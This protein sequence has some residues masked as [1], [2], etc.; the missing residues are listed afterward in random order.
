MRLAPE[1]HHGFTL[2]EL[3]VVIAILAILAA[4]L[5][6]VFAQAREKARAT[7]C[8][9][10]LRQLTM[11]IHQYMQDWEGGL[12]EFQQE[13]TTPEEYL[14]FRW[15]GHLAPYLKNREILH[16]PSDSISNARRAVQNSLP[17][18]NWVDRPELPRLSYGYNWWLQQSQET[19][20][21][22]PAETV[23]VGDC[24]GFQCYDARH[25]IAGLDISCYAFANGTLALEK[26]GVLTGQPGQERHGGGS[27]VA[28]FDGHVKFMPAGQFRKRQEGKAC[29]EYP[30]VE[31]RCEA[32]R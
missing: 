15:Y 4:I 6:P 11:A 5:F 26:Y 2:I 32:W 30:I 16:C 28:F 13:G 14:S 20:V 1:R 8:V 12:P 7:V 31:T 25:S 29:F 27:N 24:A 21:V 3:L 17:Y 23:L 18:K 22:V 10:N 19:T 9:S